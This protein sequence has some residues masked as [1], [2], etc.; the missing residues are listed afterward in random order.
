MKLTEADNR[1]TCGCWAS[2]AFEAEALDSVTGER[3][4]PAMGVRAGGK[5]VKTNFD[6]FRDVKAAVDDWAE[7]V[8][9]RFESLKQKS[10]Y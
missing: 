7:N 9:N 10:A 1:Q 6:E 4:T 8:R 2:C 5:A 3:I